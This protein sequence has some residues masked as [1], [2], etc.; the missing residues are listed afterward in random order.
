MAKYF[1]KPLS[2]YVYV[3]LTHNYLGQI[4]VN[5]KLLKIRSIIG[6]TGGHFVPCGSRFHQLKGIADS[7]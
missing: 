6:I 1:V 4:I 5:N 7:V 3:A 2:L